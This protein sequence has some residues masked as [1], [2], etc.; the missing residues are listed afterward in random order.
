MKINLYNA[1]QS[2]YEGFVQLIELDSKLAECLIEDIE[3]DMSN[4]NWFAANMCSPLGAI[5]YKSSQNLNTVSITN[6]NPKVESILT[7]NGFL[8]NY[9]RP[10]KVDAQ[11]TT[12]KY[13]RL[14]PADDRFFGDYMEKYLVG[15]GIPQMSAGLTKKF[16]ESI[17]EIFSNAAIHSNTELGI[18][19]CGQYFPNKHRL[20][21][22]IADLGMGIRRNIFETRGLDL[23]A[24]NAIDWAVKGKNTTKTGNIPGG[25]GLKLLRE[26]IELNTGRIQIISD[27]GYWEQQNDAQIVTRS[28]EHAFPGTVVNIEIN[29]SDTRSYCLKSELQSDDIF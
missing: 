8:C 24:E 26:F 17:F 28:F 27:K 25:L 20:D 29:A 2:E 18:F 16:M 9:G 6:F 5:L 11:E 19:T 23:S 7:R 12:I 21:F 1:I 14:E 10:A 4:V 3:I 15:K 13:F 22:T